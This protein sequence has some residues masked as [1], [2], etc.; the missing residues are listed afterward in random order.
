MKESNRQESQNKGS[1]ESQHELDEYSVAA[2]LRFFKLLQEWEEESKNRAD[3]DRC[4]RLHFF[5]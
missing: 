1:T 4:R 3:D 2:L 5:E